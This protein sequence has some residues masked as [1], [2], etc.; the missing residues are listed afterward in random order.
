MFTEFKLYLCLLLAI[1]LGAL[2]IKKI[3]GCLFKIIFLII[4]L[5][6]AYALYNL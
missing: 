4:V 3:T 2:F 1:V 5:L 6:L